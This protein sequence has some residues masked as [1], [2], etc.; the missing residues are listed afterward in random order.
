MEARLMDDLIDQFFNLEVMARVAP[1]IL[2]GLWQTLFLCALLLPIGLLG[3]LGTAMLATSP[4]RLLRWPTMALIDIFRAFPPLV[5]IIFIH[6]GLPFAGIRL[7]PMGS[8]CAAFLL[9]ASSYYGEIYRAGIESVGR[10]QVEAARSTGLTAGQ[11]F[12]LVVLPQAVRNVF[13]DLLSNTVELVKLTTLASVIAVPE[14]LYSA[15]LARSLTYNTSPLTM[16]ALIYLVI[17]WPLVRL[18]SRFENRI[19]AH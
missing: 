2:S 19:G 11:A 3:G 4:R 10:G 7:G 15:D 16:A 8:I 17:L 5:L 18:A 1:M 9:N 14:L 13:P 6:S 12:R